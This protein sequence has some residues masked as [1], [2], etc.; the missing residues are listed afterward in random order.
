MAFLLNS[1]RVKILGLFVLT[2]GSLVVGNALCALIGLMLLGSIAILPNRPPLL[3]WPVGLLIVIILNFLGYVFLWSRSSFGVDAV[4]AEKTLGMVGIF[5]GAV[6]F[7]RSK[8]EESNVLNVSGISF[9]LVSLLA[10][11]ST[12][13]ICLATWHFY[14]NPVSLISGFVAGGDHSMHVEITHRLM[15]WSGWRIDQVPISIFGYPKGIHFLAAQLIAVESKSSSHNT[16][17]QQ[18]LMSAW[19]DWLQLAA[20]MQCGVLIVVGKLRQARVSRAFWAVLVVGLISLVENLVAQLFWSGFTTTLGITWVLL[21]CIAIPWEEISLERPQRLPST[22]KYLVF[23]A[24]ASLIIY[25]PFV[26]IFGSLSTIY[27]LTCTRQNDLRILKPFRSNRFKLIFPILMF[28]IL[29]TTL[30]IPFVLLGLRGHVV[31]VLL[32]G[33][34]L[35][36][37][38]YQL[39]VSSFIASFLVVLFAICRCRKEGRATKVSIQSSLIMSIWALS[40]SVVVMLIKIGDFDLRNQPYYS[41]KLIWISLIASLPFLCCQILDFI[42]QLAEE[43]SK[44]CVLIPFVMVLVVGLTFSLQIE[45]PTRHGSVDWIA[46]GI[47]TDVEISEPRSMAVSPRDAL[48]THLANLAIRTRTEV[49]IPIKLALSGDIGAICNYA[50]LNRVLLIY[51]GV[52]EF[53]LLRK[54]GCGEE[55][56]YVVDGKVQN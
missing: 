53:D 21:L 25:Q 1:S 51:T 46:K 9:S 52:S 39:V 29:S 33:G 23:F 19:F 31:D 11:P 2:I 30:L 47:M 44:I 16:L 20:V 43:L 15:R 4:F 26:L 48:G 18:F 12:T 5:L 56:V 34:D 42:E 13:L 8:R 36:K 3:Y 45:T 10:I 7:I 14:V 28:L 22:V 17:T 24:V 54:S 32:V 6:A 40:F 35:A 55:I 49:N 38:N 50:R 41:Q 37:S 27:L